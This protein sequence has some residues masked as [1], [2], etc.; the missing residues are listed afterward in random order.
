MKLP[1]VTRLVDKHWRQQIATLHV[2]PGIHVLS[3]LSRR[4]SGH[5]TFWLPQVAGVP[6]QTPPAQASPNVP[7]SK[8]LHAIPLAAETQ[9]SDILAKT[10]EYNG[11]DGTTSHT[12]SNAESVA[13][14]SK[15]AVVPCC[16]KSTATCSVV[17]HM[18][19][20]KEADTASVV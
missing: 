15:R 11:Q 5:A 2:W 3:N 9:S 13:A 8:S 18:A 7:L 20:L 16:V 4:C 10:L 6:T 12:F 17:A 14:S 1:L 19:D